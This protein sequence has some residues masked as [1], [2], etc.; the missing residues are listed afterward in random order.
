MVPTAVMSRTTVKVLLNPEKAA[1]GL[2]LSVYWNIFNDEN[3][4][5]GDVEENKKIRW[6]P[7]RASAGPIVAILLAIFL[8]VTV[9]RVSFPGMK[10][11]NLE[12][13]R[14][15]LRRD[16]IK[17][18]FSLTLMFLIFTDQLVHSERTP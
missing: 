12:N 18:R 13:I 9:D 7:R 14:K 16:E 10:F 5:N 3:E 11:F 8:A 4:D 6:R 17:N 15:K 1:P 2:F